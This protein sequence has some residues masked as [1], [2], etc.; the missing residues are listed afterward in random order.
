MLKCW[1][2]LL[3]CRLLHDLRDSSVQIRV[4]V[5]SDYLNEINSRLYFSHHIRH[6]LSNSR[7]G[8]H[9]FLH[10]MLIT[11]T[12][13]LSLLQ[14]FC[15]L[16]SR[17]QE[18]RGSLGWSGIIVPTKS[19][20]KQTWHYEWYSSFWLLRGKNWSVPIP[21]NSILGSDAASLSCNTLNG[22][23]TAVCG[24]CPLQAI[25]SIHESHRL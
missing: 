22:Q 2:L 4:E 23:E 12:Y 6:G 20:E 19:V 24:I 1:W 16:F 13:I 15:E 14:T 9:D 7:F 21:T 11:M 18:N 8:R 3:H 25:Y 10:R 5:V 17:K